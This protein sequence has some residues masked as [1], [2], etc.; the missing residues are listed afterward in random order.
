[1]K[2]LL[3]DYYGFYVEQINNGFFYYQNQRYLLLECS[4]TPEEVFNHYYLYSLNFQRLN[5]KPYFILIENKYHQILSLHYI[6][7]QLHFET[8][9]LE[10]FIPFSLQPLR[11]EKK[12]HLINEWIKLM[13]QVEN[14]ILPN[15]KEELSFDYI[16]ALITYALGIGENALGYLQDQLNFNQGYPYSLQID[17]FKIKSQ[18]DLS[19]TNFYFDHYLDYLINLY[20]GG[21]ISLESLYP[22]ISGLNEQDCYYIYARLLFPKSYFQC[23]LFEKDKKVLLQRS[24]HFY[25]N[26]ELYENRIRNYYSLIQ[27]KI[28]IRPLEWME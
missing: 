13:D 2:N 12:D 15:I 22:F 7:Y 14:E 9:C 27:Q 20:Q 16:Y 8:I 21:F 26:I 19:P 11:F 28:N 4:L 5:Q 1:M 24:I 25:K 6:L 23:L 10:D 3:Y 18:I 17:P